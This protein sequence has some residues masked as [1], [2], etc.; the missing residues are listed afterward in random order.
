MSGTLKYQ[1]LS[2]ELQARIT[3]D[4]NGALS[5]DDY[6]VRRSASHDKANLWRPAFVRDVEKILHCSY[7]NRYADKTQVFSF[8]KNDDISHRA[9]HVQLVSRIAR[10]IGRML[11]L[12]LDLI[13]AI[14]L[15]HDIGHTPFGHA[16][17]R[18]LN[19]LYHE[20]T[21]RFFNHNVHSVRVLD[22]ILNLNLS[23]QT[24]DGIL[25]HNG[26]FECKEYHPAPLSGFDEFDRKVEECYTDSSAIG[27]LVPSTLEGC[28]VRVCDMIAYIGKD[29]QDAVRT[30]TINSEDIFGENAIGRVNAQ[31]IN[32][33]I[34]N[35]IENSYGKDYIRLDGEH[36]ESLRQSKADN[37]RLIYRNDELAKK[38]DEI[39]K[40][41]F[42]RI[43]ERI[44]S[45]LASEN[46]SSPVFA[47]HIEHI[48]RE[49]R[50]RHGTDYRET[51]P[52]QIAV[53]YI[54]SMTDDYFI[55]LYEYLFNEPSGV[56]YISYFNGLDGA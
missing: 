13:E 55:D 48:K 29:R 21:G 2:E 5:A 42:G 30:H 22:K 26:E 44:L 33:M 49:T 35:I 50:F 9:F 56:E 37:Y 18:F 20:R 45:D 23:L 1:K 39:I 6:A 16:G 27:R 12:N 32:N 41:M 7:Y 52:N 28:V 34:V 4:S 14:A 10:N 15:G 46:K 54:A 11:G 31:I 19:E 53:D 51:E 8:Y 38:Y 24:L 40:P 17:E 25:C 47:H 3:A 36:Y 43:Y